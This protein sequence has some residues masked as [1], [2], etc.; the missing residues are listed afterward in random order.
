[1]KVKYLFSSLLVM[2]CAVIATPW[3][4][5][6]KV[7][8]LP[9]DKNNWLLTSNYNGAMVENGI[10]EIDTTGAN[11]RSHMYY[12]ENILT[13]SND[14]VIEA[15]A[16][17]PEFTGSAGCGIWFA[18]GVN[19]EAL[20]FTA[21]GGRLH[22]SGL[23]FSNPAGFNSKE[24]H[25]YKIVKTG[26]TIDVYLDGVSILSGA[27]IYNVASTR[28]WIAFGD[29]ASVGSCKGYWDFIRYSVS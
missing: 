5:E 28:N 18:N 2:S 3:L 13:G 23:S 7:D 24:F 22:Y 14:F 17:H 27:N 8:S 21:A 9:N 1:M 20:L 6:Y 10:L 4:N 12:V 11:A 29:G 19:E 16:K 15:R 25:T 26:S